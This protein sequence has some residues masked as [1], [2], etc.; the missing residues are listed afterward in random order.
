MKTSEQQVFHVRTYRQ[1][2]PIEAYK[3]QRYWC[4][5]QPTQSAIA[6]AIFAHGL[7]LNLPAI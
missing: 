2:P 1:L 3:T 4:N 7:P 6:N 5:N